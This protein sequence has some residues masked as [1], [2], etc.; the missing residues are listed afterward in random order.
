[1]V[2]H[3]ISGFDSVF[4]PW[5]KESG[6]TL[7]DIMTENQ[8]IVCAEWEDYPTCDGWKMPTLREVASFYRIRGGKESMQ[9]GI[10]TVKLIALILEKMLQRARPQRVLVSA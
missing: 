3:N 8:N 10:V 6:T 5:L 1:L 7:F 2:G 4:L 9:S